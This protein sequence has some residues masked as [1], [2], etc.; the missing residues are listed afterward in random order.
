[1]V[2]EFAMSTSETQMVDVR[3]MSPAI[4]G[5]I[6]VQMHK[7]FAYVSELINARHEG[8]HFW[9][10]VTILNLFISSAINVIYLHK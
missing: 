3:A 4:G 7:H 1:M 5:M 10:L 9:E 2:L 8:S 6:A